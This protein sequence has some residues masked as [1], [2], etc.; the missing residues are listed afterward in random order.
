MKKLIFSA[1]LLAACAHIP[2]EQP[3]YV[4]ALLKNEIITNL[5][6]YEVYAVAS[7][8]DFK[9]EKGL[10]HIHGVTKRKRNDNKLY[11]EFDKVIFSNG[12]ERAIKGN[13][14][15][16]SE[17]TYTEGLEQFAIFQNIP[18][19]TKITIKLQ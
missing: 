15:T 9:S 17:K 7:A 19:G 13:A 3:S 5:A 12:K 11:I 2:K 1:S 14:Y 8:S 4:P 6:S 10:V 18:F 16:L